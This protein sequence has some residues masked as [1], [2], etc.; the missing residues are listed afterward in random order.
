M[1]TT[2]IIP[3]RYLDY[4]DESNPRPFYYKKKPI[5]DHTLQSAVDAKSI[6]RII[7]AYDDER[8]LSELSKWQSY[9]EFCK[10][11]NFLSLEGVTTLDVL[12]Y[13]AQHIESIYDVNYLMLLEISHPDRPNGLLDNIIETAKKTPADSHITVKLIK[14]NYWV[15]NNEEG[16]SRIIGGGENSNISIYRELLGIG[17]LFSTQT[18]LSEE[19]IGNNV[20]MIP[21]NG[22]W[23]DIDIRNRFNNEVCPV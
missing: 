2:A 1:K 17:S 13:V 19:P 12:Q 23:V 18:C 21:L 10:R 16:S 15:Q 11:P 8:Y 6:Q 22:D 7:V 9:V 4:F 14:Y 20:N 3:I 5:W